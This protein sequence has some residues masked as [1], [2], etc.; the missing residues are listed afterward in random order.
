M[1]ILLALAVVVNLTSS[2][3]QAEG[4]EEFLRSTTKVMVITIDDLPVAQQS[5]DDPLH[6]PV[7]L[8]YSLDLAEMVAHQDIGDE[9]SVVDLLVDVLERLRVAGAELGALTAN[10]PHVFFERIQA[11][12]SLPLISIVDATL[13]RARDLGVRRALLLG[14]RATMEGSMYASAFSPDGIKVVIPDHDDRD[15]INRSIYRDLAAG[16][17]TPELRETY[18]EICRRHIESDG[19]DAVILACTEIPLVLAEGDLPVPLV[20][21]ARC[22]AEAIFARASS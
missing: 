16:T 13:E 3:V 9:D 11:A 21:T 6:N 12:T 1:R 18:L 19:V 20:D 22:H 8:I 7:V 5:W 17:V 15:F 10:T 14:T 2:R 4:P